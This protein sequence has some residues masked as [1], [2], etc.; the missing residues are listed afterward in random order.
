MKLISHRGNIN[1]PN[2]CEENHPD[3]IR[4][5]MRAGFQ[6]ELDL[7]FEKPYTLALG[8]DKPLYPISRN[9]LVNN[10]NRLWIHCKNIDALLYCR[11]NLSEANYFFHNVDDVV[12]TSWNFLWHYIDRGPYGHNSICVLPELGDLKDIPVCYGVCS[13]YVGE[14]NESG[15]YKD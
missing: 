2:S 1:G 7:W 3:S 9:F 11:G 13:D 4:A 15:R 12:L 5:A 8:H 10:L 6:S 14:L